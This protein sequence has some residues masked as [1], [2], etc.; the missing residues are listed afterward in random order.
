MGIELDRTVDA[1]PVLMWT[2][3][4]D[5]RPKSFDQCWRD[6]AGLSA[7]QTS[8]D[9]WLQVVHP[10]DRAALLAAWQG[11]LDSGKAAEAQARMWR[12][13]GVYR[14]FLLRANPVRDAAGKILEWHILGT[15]IEE[16]KR[17]QAAE[18]VHEQS[19]RL[20]IDNLP[21][22]MV[23]FKPNGE[24]LHAN[25]Q[26]LEYAGASLAEA[27]EWTSRIHPDD[28]Q[29]TLADF[30]A[31]LAGGE[32]YEGD[33]RHRRADGVYRWFHA[34]GAPL[35]D[36][37]GRIVLWY[38]HCTDIDE[39]KRA[40]A[41]L[42][43]ENRLL[44]M[45][46]RAAPLHAVL[47]ALCQLSEEID[48]GCHSGI[49]LI[50]PLRK[51]FQ[52]GGTSSRT[53]AYIDAM[54]GAPV[55]TQ[56]APSAVAAFSG[57][58]LIIEDVAADSRWSQHFRDM[59]LAQGLRACWLMPI[60]SR[61]REA[62]GVLAVYRTEPGTPTAFQRDLIGQLSHIAS[63]AIE[64]A[65]SDMAVRRSMEGL[66]AI[67]ETTPECVTLVAGDGTLLQVNSAGA[68]IAGVPSV[69]VL[70]GKCFFDF[71]VP[72]HRQRYIDF[73]QR[74]CAGEKR[75]LEFDII[76]AHGERRHMESYSA[77]MESMDGI[78]AQLGVTRDITARRLA[79]EELRRR[80]ALMAKSQQ[81]SSS[82]SF[83][84]R[85]QSKEMLWSAQTYR[86][87]GVEPGT[88]VTQ[89]VV[90]ARYHPGDAHVLQD[91]LE[92]AQL[93]LDLEYDHRL[94]MPDGSVKYLSVQAHSTR[95]ALGRLEYIGAVRDVTEHHRSE[96]TLSQLRTE[97]AHVTRVHS[98]GALTASIAHEINQPLA[99][100]MTNASTG[101]RMLGAEP[102]NVEGALQTLQRTLRDGRRASEVVTRLRALFSKKEVRNE[103][104]DLN[105][106]TWEVVDLLRS[107]MRRKRI[108]LQQERA[109]DLPP[110]NGDKVQLQ[111][112]VLNLLTN[113]I[114]AMNDVEG[115]PRQLLVKT[116]REAGD[117]GDSVRVAVT[118]TGSGFDPQQATK[119]FEA[120]FTT[121]REGMGIGLSVSRSI[122]ESHGGRMW[123]TAND[124]PGATF[125][126]SIPCRAS[127]TAASTG[128]P[129]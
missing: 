10:D 90:A 99:G 22:I 54:H 37:E 126:F 87:F 127:G 52:R 14:W 35:R 60:H 67:V 27:A 81:L 94:L 113:A 69:D 45:V 101:V 38:F 75:T 44:E 118:D 85:P 36:E 102:P 1:L 73:H 7:E 28:R 91:L 112:V 5:G 61:N 82:G 2:A 17:G 76:T 58:P 30:Q 108:V 117:A 106:A 21:A 95:D 96:E 77:P 46:A 56:T 74:V 110:V 97:L 119:L 3:C 47:D 88:P 8:G 57:A 16:R 93:G 24:V 107:A 115:R 114:D 12:K 128:E 122:I 66:R 23:L 9:G 111:Q 84:W 25:R 50:D 65:Q 105:E 78:T 6:Y 15:D 4:P 121:K 98:L 39:R 51:I 11:G 72:E 123:A 116:A 29:A 129:R 53:S 64:R 92:R 26:A 41:L 63:I 79:E 18:R 20:M 32:P 19:F 103:P 109:E 124:G 43:G 70:I 55:N 86:I 59:S 49:L 33:W 48:N 40:K 13:D 71:V 62:L 68:S 89:E 83:S 120:F 125:S 34:R 31:T 104:V 100:I 80:E 42:A